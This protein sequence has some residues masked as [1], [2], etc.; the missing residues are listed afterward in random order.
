MPFNQLLT[1]QSPIQSTREL[2]NKSA[3]KTNLP[4]NSSKN[5]KVQTVNVKKIVW[6]FPVCHQFPTPK[7]CLEKPT[8]HSRNP[9]KQKIHFLWC[10]VIPIKNYYFSYDWTFFFSL[11]FSFLNLFYFII[12]AFEKQCERS[13][14]GRRNYLHIYDDAM[15]YIKSSLWNL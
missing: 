10:R 6:L 15:P 14:R 7:R 5:R 2:L 13:L 4:T 3:T 1:N 8:K 9:S 12:F 11:F